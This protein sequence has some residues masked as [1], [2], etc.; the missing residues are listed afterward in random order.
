[1]LIRGLRFRPLPS[2]HRRFPRGPPH[3]APKGPGGLNYPMTRNQKGHRIAANGGANGA[4]GI[5][6]A[7]FLGDGAVGGQLPH[8]DFEQGFPYF[9][10]KIGAFQV[11]FDFMQFAPVILKNEQGILLNH[12]QLAAE[13]C[14]GEM[15]L[16]RRKRSRL[17][18]IKPH[19]TNPFDGGSHNQVAK[20]AFGKA[21]IDIQVFCAVFVL[22]WRHAF[23]V[24]EEVV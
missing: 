5:R 24:D 17:I 6:V 16:K 12:I 9:E 23:D 18:F 13:F 20:R 21:V 14:I 10:L 7:N 3:V 8:R 19:K 15:G 4:G 1:M 22:R 11:Q 2:N